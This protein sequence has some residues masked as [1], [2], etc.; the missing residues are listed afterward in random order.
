MEYHESDRGGW[1]ITNPIAAAGAAGAAQ[2]F[3]LSKELSLREQDALA[4]RGAF[5]LRGGEIKVMDLCYCPFSRTC[6]SCDK[7][8]VYT[9]TDEA[10][11][12]FPM[13]RY[14]AAE[15][16]RFELFNCARLSSEGGAP[17]ALF[18]GSLAERAEQAQ[19]TKG[20]TIRSML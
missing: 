11:R 6:A 7:R 9:L 15:G 14:R 8:D 13:R 17:S 2:Y 20:H 5:A 16:C 1:N 3:A 10:G 19:T 12:A 4:L 18:D